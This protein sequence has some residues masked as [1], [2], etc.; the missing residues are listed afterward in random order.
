MDKHQYIDF[1]KLSESQYYA[2][3]LAEEDCTPFLIPQFQKAAF[4]LKRFK[5]YN[6]TFVE[7]AYMCQMMLWS[8]FGKWLSEISEI[9][10][11][12]S[13]IPQL[14]DSTHRLAESIQTRISE[15]LHNYY[16][17]NLR[18]ESYATRQ[19]KLNR[20]VVSTKSFFQDQK[21]KI[22]A[23]KMFDFAKKKIPCCPF[24]LNFFEFFD[25]K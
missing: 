6:P 22:I 16:I 9:K 10:F 25:I 24:M 5:K 20:M 3:Q 11:E 21:Q 7:F 1:S 19:A 23:A 8:T 15:D 2:T 18:L 4:G 12:F 17:N 13:E 14:E